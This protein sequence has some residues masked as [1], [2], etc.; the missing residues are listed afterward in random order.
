MDILSQAYEDW[1]SMLPTWFEQNPL[2]GILNV[3]MAPIM[4]PI[5]ALSL[6]ARGL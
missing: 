6:L 4:I 1:S 5:Y 2:I 3:I